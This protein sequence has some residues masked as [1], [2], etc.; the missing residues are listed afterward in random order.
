M[1]EK[2]DALPCAEL[3]F[4]LGNRYGFTGAC[5]HHSNVRWHVVAA[6]GTVRE[7]IGIFRNEPLEKFFQIAARSGIG[8]FHDDKATTGVVSKNSDC[9][10]LHVG[11]IELRLQ[12]IGDFVE[13][14]TTRANLKSIMMKAHNFKPKIPCGKVVVAATALNNSE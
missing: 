4:A 8:I 14:L 2:K 3:H 12:L 7:I 6:L 9:T 5:Q 11:P 13:T 10:A 1:F